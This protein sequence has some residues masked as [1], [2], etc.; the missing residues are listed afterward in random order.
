MVHGIVAWKLSLP[1]KEKYMIKNKKQKLQKI[2]CGFLCVGILLMQPGAAF[3][4]EN[5]DKA[6]APTVTATPTPI[7]H[8][9][10]Y[11]EPAQTDSLEGWP[12]GPQIEGKSAVVMDMQTG[13]VIYAKNPDEKLYPASITKIMTTLLACENLDMDDTIVVSQAAAYGIEAGSS[14]IY[15]DTGEVFTVEQALMA[16]MLESANEM[17]LAVAEKVSGSVKKF[18]ELMNVRAKQLGCTGTHFNNPNGLPDKNHYTTA[19]DM[20]KIAKAAW[21]NPLFRKF[22]SRDLYE[23]PPTNVQTETRYLLNHHKMMEG[24]DY[25]YDGVMGGKTGYTTDAGNTLVTYAKRGEMR[26][27]T[28]VL[29][30]ING[31]YSDTAS[32]LDY[33]FDNFQKVSMKVDFGEDVVPVAGLP[34]EKYILKNLGDTWPFYFL[35]Q[36]YV[37][38]PKGITS[39]QI[40]R[41]QTTQKNAVG[42]P[43]VLNEYFYDDH[44]VG[45]GIQYEREVMSDLLLNFSS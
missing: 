11:S 42:M 28:V 21:Y 36:V 25:A 20:A 2:L 38:V 45:T 33:G 5:T 22:T 41:V 13:S 19:S 40:E 12:T 37:T 27:V 6:A 29:N 14:S 9:E 17:S 35:H 18:V 43:T 3:A 7:P 23:I 31:A 24:R 39:D 34:C 10:A 26:L 8:T 32:L 44:L 16:V 15:A 4:S 1:V 30:S